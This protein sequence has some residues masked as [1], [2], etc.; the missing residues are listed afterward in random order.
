MLKIKTRL[1][2]GAIFR[3]EQT[4]REYSV[5]AV[6]K[7]TFGGLEVLFPGWDPKDER[8][9]VVSPH[10]DDAIIGTG[11]VM[12]AALDAGAEVHVIIVCNGD[13]GY[14]TVEE[15]DTIVERRHRETVNVYGAF[16]VPEENIIFLNFPDFSAINYVGRLLSSGREGDFR[17]TITEMRK[18]RITR[19]LAPNHYHEHLDHVAASMIAQY[20][21]PQVGDVHSVDWADPYVVRSCAQYSVWAELDP[22]D[23]LVDGR[24]PA[25]RADTVMIASPDVEEKVSEGLHEYVSQREIIADLMEQRK[26]RQLPDGRF[27]EVYRRFDPRPKLSFDP[28]K[29]LIQKLL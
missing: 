7:E 25:L 27:I 2:R 18:R 28:Y 21:A 6:R 14:S 24:N 1:L 29:E 10:D 22:E 3:E 19:I 5:L 17:K 15:K 26:G 11:Y 12:R 16:G 23:A 13:C 20:N 8:I 9:C 4:L